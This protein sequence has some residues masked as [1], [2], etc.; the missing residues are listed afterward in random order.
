MSDFA[1]WLK[2]YFDSL[3][4]WI[5]VQIGAV[6]SGL[7]DLLTDFFI[8]VLDK[9]FDLVTYIVSSMTWDFTGFYPVQ[10]YNALPS[11]LTSVFNLLGVPTALAMIVAALTIRFVLQMIPFVRWGS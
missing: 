4:A 9:L 2:S 7:W 11:S 1:G 6:F 5:L 10:Y 3:I 8:Y